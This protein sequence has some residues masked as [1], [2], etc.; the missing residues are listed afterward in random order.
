MPGCRQIN[1]ALFGGG[2]WVS[3]IEELYWVVL[4]GTRGMDISQALLTVC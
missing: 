1:K 2:I 4:T 3:E